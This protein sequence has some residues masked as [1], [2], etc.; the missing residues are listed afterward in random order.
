MQRLHRPIAHG[1]DAQRALATIRLGDVYPTQRLRLVT[2]VA[3]VLDRVPLVVR[4]IPAL[5]VNSRSL[6]TTVLRHS[7]NR[8][9][10]RA[11][12]PS[13]KPLQGAHFPPLACFCCF[14]NTC[15]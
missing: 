2:L 1:G 9:R 14:R 8:Q 12:G 10:F 3:Q 11:R 5:A 6:S 4:S 15:L 7:A 13:E